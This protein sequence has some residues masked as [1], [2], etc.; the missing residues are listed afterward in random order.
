MATFTIKTK[1][2]N[3]KMLLN[4]VTSLIDDIIKNFNITWNSDQQRDII[5]EV[6]D[7]HMQDLAEAHKILRWDVVCDARN[8]KQ[9]DIKQNITHLD[10]EYTQW[11]CY[12]VSEI[13]Y[14]IQN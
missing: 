4:E 7:E 14:I 12:N 13:K 3:S 6:I 1:H 5:F 10:I 9:R 8:N 2:I 11:N